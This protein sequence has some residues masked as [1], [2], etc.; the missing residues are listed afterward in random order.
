MLAQSN[1]WLYKIVSNCPDVMKAFPSEDLAKGLQ[2]LDLGQHF[3]PIQHSLGLGWDLST[4]TFMFQVADSKKPF[5]RCGVLS[6]I[7]SLF[8]PLG[9]ATPVSIEGCHILSELSSA[10]C[11]W[12]ALLPM[13]KHELWMKWKNCLQDLQRL[14][15]PHMYTTVPLSAATKK[16]VCVFC[17]AS[18]KVIGAVVDLKATDAVGN[19]EVGFICSKGK[20]A[21][22]LGGKFG[23]KYHVQQ[24]T[25]T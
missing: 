3:P 14:K 12:D 9:F 13:E 2:D 22:K 23:G 4:D 7:N 11:D 16:E 17:D 1:L 21:L 6:T 5:T 25:T 10:A 24:H 8:D 15:I 20:L 18:V 19:N